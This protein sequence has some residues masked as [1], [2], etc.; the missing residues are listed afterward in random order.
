MFIAFISLGLVHLQFVSHLQLLLPSLCLSCVSWYSTLFYYPHNILMA[1]A[2]ETAS[3][4]SFVCAAFAQG[5][6][7]E[8]LE[9]SFVFW[10]ALIGQLCSLNQSVLNCTQAW[11]TSA[12]ATFHA[13][14]SWLLPWNSFSSSL[15]VRLPRFI[16]ILEHSKPYNMWL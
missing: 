12:R 9:K 1:C 3:D 14:A 10:N 5:C 16:S 8:A 7:M 4:F 6:C 13:S 11:R 2:S 15:Y